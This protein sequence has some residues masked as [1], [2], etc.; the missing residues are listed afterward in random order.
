MCLNE[1]Y[2]VSVMY[3]CKIKLLLNVFKSILQKFLLYTTENIIPIDTFRCPSDI[4]L[5]F[6]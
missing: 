3:Y 6:C 5:T 2:E 1:A 4:L